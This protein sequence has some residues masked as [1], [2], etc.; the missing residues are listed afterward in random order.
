MALPLVWSVYDLL[1]SHDKAHQPVLQAFAAT[2][3][4]GLGLSA[5]L[6]TISLK[7]Q[8]QPG[9]REAMF[10]VSSAWFL[11]AA[12][13]AMP[14]YSWAFLSGSGTHEFASY[15]NCYFESI[16]GLTTTG[17]SILSDIESVPRGLLLW[18]ALSQ[19][20]GGLGIVVLFVAVMPLLASTNKRIFQAESS[21]I[22]KNQD[23]PSLQE[24]ARVLWLIYT[25]LTILQTVLLRMADP[26]LG[27]FSA[28]SF[29]FSTAATAGFSIFNQSAGG[30]SMLSQWICI[31][32]MFIAGVNYSLYFR[33][34]RGKPG[35][36]FRDI[37]FRV[38]FLTLAGAT[39]IL[40]LYIQGYPYHDMAGQPASS[41][42]FRAVTDAAF[43]SVSIQ[44]TTGF[45]T[46]DSD[47]W[48]VITHLVLVVLMLIGGCAGSTGGGIKVIRFVALFKMIYAEIER[49][50]RPN[51]VRPCLVGSGTLT[52]SQRHS[53][54]IHVFMVFALIAAGGFLLL[55]IE[56]P[57]VMDLSTALTA[58][59]ASVNNIGPGFS[60]VGA[61]QNYSFLSTPSKIL[62]AFLMGVGRLEVFT[63]MALFTPRFWRL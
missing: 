16:S 63:V 1:I 21:G 19:W 49:V 38:Y 57:E 35:D 18:R 31:I 36:L 7:S 56:G 61:T 47:Q 6:Y 34:V 30:I 26:D 59:T 25:G 5:L 28:L 10:I 52:Q 22:G 24:M 32:F 55:A 48:P 53:V 23:T 45:S 60:L 46:A 29:A 8:G 3:L 17:A 11:G 15:V 14:Y 54:L 37:E 51:V 43:Q 62:L 27:W 58:A 13:G 12:L 42:T 44:T 20:I 41:T 39:I 2:I 33:L 4:T 50:Y 40:Y 9:R